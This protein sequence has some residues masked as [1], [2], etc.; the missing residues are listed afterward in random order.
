MQDCDEDEFDAEVQAITVKKTLLVPS[1]SAKYK[2]YN[3]ITI[4]CDI[5]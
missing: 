1:M 2:C 4:F 5:S 3:V